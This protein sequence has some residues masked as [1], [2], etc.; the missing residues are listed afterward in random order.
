MKKKIGRYSF[1]LRPIS[2][3]IDLIIIN[4]LFV[5]TDFKNSYYLREYLETLSI[6][7]FY[8]FSLLSLLWVAITFFSKFYEVYRFTTEIR[9]FT[10]IFNQFFIFT[11]FLFGI[12]GSTDLSISIYNLFGFILSSLICV[13]VVKFFI[14]YILRKF[15]LGFGGNN[16]KIIIIGKDNSTDELEEFFKMKKELGYNHFKTFDTKTN[17]SLA[18]AV[19]YI[20]RKNI[21]EIYCSVDQLN[22][23]QIRNIIDYCDNHFKTLKFLPRRDNLYYKQLDFQTYGY[24]TVQSFRK[25]PLEADTVYFFIKR[26]YDIIF[27][28]MVIFLILSWLTPIIAI[29]INLDSKGPIFFKQ[30]RNGYK[31]KEFYCYKFRSMIVNDDANEKT[32]TKKDLRVTS[33]G[34]FLRKSSLD[35]M[36]QFI[37]VLIGD[38][39]VVGPRPH[40][41][42]EN[43]KYSKTVNK[44]MLRH[45]VKPGITGL[46]QI[47]GYRGEI[48][49]DKDIINRI[50]YDIYYIQNWSFI[51]DIKVTIKT[52]INFL[53]GGEEKAY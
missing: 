18:Q 26:I 53:K 40:M 10:L 2:I 11:L 34:K 22:S 39:S 24:S 43:L 20:H 46:A 4:C 36:P 33:F 8:I 15:R 27:S 6:N 5:L 29:L 28:L 50:K 25:T 16:R 32:A 19:N 13:S 47:N 1:Y 7:S 14:F 31:Y 30:A 21:D 52:T 48:E 38:M 37:N 42:K 23:S 49:T 3:A 9:I 41:I 12:F 45:S 44:F 17:F 35:E 51:L